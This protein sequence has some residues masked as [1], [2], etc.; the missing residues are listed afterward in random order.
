MKTLNL[1][2]YSIS[3]CAR[4]HIVKLRFD[5]SKITLLL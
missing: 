1:I 3:K 5:I 2:T 4:E